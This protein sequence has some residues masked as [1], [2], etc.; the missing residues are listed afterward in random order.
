MV[1]A[2]YIKGVQKQP[3][4]DVLQ[5]RMF[6]LKGFAKFLGKHLCRS[7]FNK[8]AHLLFYNLCEIFKNI[9]F[10]ITPQNQIYFCVNK[11]V[12]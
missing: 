3:S 10:L 6:Y 7:H 5:S 11:S 9:Y 8:V 2:Y 4:A 12:K 1:E